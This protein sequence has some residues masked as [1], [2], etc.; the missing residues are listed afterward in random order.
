MH[1]HYCMRV[2]EKEKWRL[3]CYRLLMSFDCENC[4]WPWR[5]LLLII[6]DYDR[7]H[8]SI[9]VTFQKWNSIEKKRKKTVGWATNGYCTVVLIKLNYMSTIFVEIFNI[10]VSWPRWCQQ[11]K[12]RNKKKKRHIIALLFLYFLFRF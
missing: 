8:I 1:I 5:I 2:R 11:R 4:Q 12:K 9:N 10:F 6:Y 3:I 7:R